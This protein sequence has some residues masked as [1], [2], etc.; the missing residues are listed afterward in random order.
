MKMGKSSQHDTG[1]G[2]CG[3]R[4]FKKYWKGQKGL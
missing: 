2:E 1:T 4:K 3:G